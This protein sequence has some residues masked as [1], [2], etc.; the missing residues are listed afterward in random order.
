MKKFTCEKCNFYTNLTNNYERHLNTF[1]HLRKKGIIKENI[2]KSQKEPKKSQKEPLKSKKEPKRAAKQPQSKKEYFCDYCL[3]KFSSYAIKRRHEKHRCKKNKEKMLTI[4]NEKDKLII[5]MQHEKEDLYKKI[6]KL[7]DKIGDTTNITNITINN[8]GN[9]DMSHITDNFKTHLL[10]IPYCMIH[11]MIEAVHFND[12]KPENKNIC[13]ANKKENLLKVYKNNKWI[14]K[15]KDDTINDL[16]DEKYM[17]LDTH[18]DLVEKKQ[19]IDKNIKTNYLK[20]RKFYDEE[21]K[22]MVENL[23][24]ECE[25]VLLN[26]R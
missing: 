5:Q 12:K 16:V 17:I 26:N 10:K 3:E 9:E 22:N 4:I 6:D 19:I 20:F 1:K 14:Y 24:K 13:L 18:Y 2:V 21:D 11:K 7:L 15:S 25:L 8:Y 23:K